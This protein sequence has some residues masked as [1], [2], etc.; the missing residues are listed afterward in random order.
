MTTEIRNQ[1]TETGKFS[2]ISDIRHP[3]SGLRGF[4]LIETLVA[5]TI[6]TIAVSGPLFTASRAI[7]A[8]QIARDQLTASYL[9]QEGI[10]YV[11]AMRDNEYLSAYQA[12]GLNV[13]TAA[14][15]NFLA[16][17]INQ[18]RG[19]ICT[20]DPSKP[21]DSGNDMSLAPCSGSCAPLHLTQLSNGTYGYTQQ[22]GGTV[23]HF[24]R[25]IQVIDASPS[26]ATDVRV[27][28]K[29]SWDFHNTP[30]SISIS[31]HLTPWQ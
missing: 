23:T 16:G 29:V 25:T 22:S 30:Y 1:K 6:I 10:E 20:L 17:S 9:A 2:S 19:S 4:T 12:S 28:S 27:I 31:D 21:M 26:G 11:R 18:C 3:T 24:I 14:W 15:N 13:S 7:V 8:A 5:I